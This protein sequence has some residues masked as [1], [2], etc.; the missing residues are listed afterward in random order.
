M[1]EK[2]EKIKYLEEEIRKLAEVSVDDI[3]ELE[4]IVSLE[5]CNYRNHFELETEA[6]KE[7]IAL[8][9]LY[10]MVLYFILGSFANSF[11]HVLFVVQG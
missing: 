10:F 5:S 3:T 2:S 9:M 11:Q 6:L 7:D 1:P 8:V 4:D